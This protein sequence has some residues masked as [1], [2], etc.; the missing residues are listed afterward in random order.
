MNAH[1]E[2][3]ARYP[4][5]FYHLISPDDPKVT[6]AM[7]GIRHGFITLAEVVLKLPDNRE[8]AIAMTHLQTALMFTIA[9]TAITCGS[10]EM[11]DTVVGNEAAVTDMP[12]G[13]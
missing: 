1:Q 9:S 5:F 6:V 10:P 7:R 8:K 2:L 4:G 11:P 3:L 12:A 13:D